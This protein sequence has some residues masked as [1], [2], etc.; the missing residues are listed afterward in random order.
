MACAT[1]EKRIRLTKRV[2]AKTKGA[3]RNRY[4]QKLA[5]LQTLTPNARF[6]KGAKIGGQGGWN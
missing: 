6:Y 5:F 4:E 1:K 2:I 3:K